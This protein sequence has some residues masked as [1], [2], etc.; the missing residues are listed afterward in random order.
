[1]TRARQQ[2]GFTLVEVLT[3]LVI[4]GLM[5]SVVIMSLPSPKPAAVEVSDRLIQE[6]N[7]AA[8]AGLIGGDTVAF[9]ASKE[10]YE[11]YRFVGETWVS[12]QT[13]HWDDLRRVELSVEGLEIELGEQAVPLVI[14]EPSGVAIPFELALHDND[15]SRT[16]IGDGSGRVRL[17]ARP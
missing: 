14:F 13:G 3:V 5:S 17:E 16:L 11:I 6:L 9:G 12:E 7:R 8:Q 15:L 2:S 1:M 10:G 4:I